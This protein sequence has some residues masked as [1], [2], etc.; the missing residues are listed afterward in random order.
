MTKRETIYNYYYSGFPIKLT[1]E[2]EIDAKMAATKL[3]L[4]SSILNDNDK[5]ITEI[6]LCPAK[7]EC[8]PF[9]IDRI[10]LLISPPHPDRLTKK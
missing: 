8:W 5:L 3:L 4:K 6:S 10:P 9:K 7:K 1:S 2:N